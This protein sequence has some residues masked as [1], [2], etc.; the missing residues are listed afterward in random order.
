MKIKLIREVKTDLS[1][2][3]SLYIN[4]KYFCKTLEPFD[5]GLD[6]HSTLADIYEAKHARKCAIPTGNY[7]I[8]VNQTS[9]RFGKLA[10]YSDFG[11]IVPRYEGIKGFAGVLMHIGN[12]PKDTDGCTLVGKYAKENAVTDSRVTWLAL[13]DILT[14]VPKVE[15]IYINVERSY[16]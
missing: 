10:P 9:P 12:F 1:S 15:R 7:T 6:E 14:K 11:G 16:K 4:D 8:S 3:G 2:I 13:M 5:V